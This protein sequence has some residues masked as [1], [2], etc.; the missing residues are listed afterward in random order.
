MLYKVYKREDILEFGDFQRGKKFYMLYLHYVGDFRFKLFTIKINAEPVFV[1][2]E[3]RDVIK[4]YK[5]NG[6]DV[7]GYPLLEETKID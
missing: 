1:C 4:F 3:L 6:C 5:K 2:D 7:F